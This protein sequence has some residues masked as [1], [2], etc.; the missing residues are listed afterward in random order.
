MRNSVFSGTYELG[1]TLRLV[2]ER[3]PPSWRLETRP[4]ASTVSLRAPDGTIARLTVLR[5]R[6][7]EPKDVQTLQTSSQ[8]GLKGT[9]VTAGF[10]SPRTRQLLKEAGA[11]YA[12]ASGNMRVVADRPGIF[13]E[14]EGAQKN[15]AREPRPLVSLK[16][17]AA[18][19]VVRALCDFRPPYGVRRLA[20]IAETAPAS[21]S[22]VV[23]LLE[24][25]ALIER[26]PRDEIRGVD[27]AGLLQRWSQDYQFLSSNDVTTFLDPRGLPSFP[28][29]LRN[30]KARA[31]VTGSLAAVRRAP[32]ASPR[33]AAV[34]V[35]DPEAAAR[36]LALRPA[37]SGGNVTLVRPFDPVAF[38]RSWV[39]EGIRYAALSQVAADLLTSPGRGP[40][41][42]EELIA[43]MKK[44]TDVW[45]A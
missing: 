12:D 35:D 34:Y 16:G 20:E 27:W 10:L 40:S 21:A 44:N 42:G 23:G 11:S 9:L 45:R 18:A 41:E 13:V 14:A 33:L 30:L 25:E 15:P 39:D 28:A 32:V 17:P 1:T 38:A 31:A 6:K 7:L 4:K 3:L 37:E 2:A 19:R 24:R 5:R 36:A 29:K 26:G 22:R 8:Q 43:W